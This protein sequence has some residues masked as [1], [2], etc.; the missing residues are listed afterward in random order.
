MHRCVLYIL[1]V[2]LIPAWAV[3]QEDTDRDRRE[4]LN[5]TFNGYK[6]YLQDRKIAAEA[7][8]RKAQSKAPDL[9]AP[10]YNLG[11]TQYRS[12]SYG[13]AFGYFKKAAEH[14]ETRSERH[15]AYH[16]MGNVLMQK[17]DYQGAVKAYKEALKNNPAD[18][19]TRYN[20]ALAKEMLKKNPPQNQNQNQNQNQDQENKDGEGNQDNKDKGDQGEG[21]DS[22][23]KGDS[24]K[25]GS[26]GEDGDKEKKSGDEGDE[27]DP[28]DGEDK[29]QDK[30]SEKPGDKKDDKQENNNKQKARPKMDQLSKQNLLNLLEALE[31]E[32]KRVQ[33]KVQAQKVKGKPIKTDK[34]W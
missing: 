28:K 20:Y 2:S 5:M 9:S 29:S 14:A 21:D 8:F 15:Q 19:E 25:G 11:T 3:A 17:K 31:N 34:D 23:Q 1:F 18:D 7:T 16:N 13:E 26:D 27:D 12:D 10:A 24:D 4:A 33:E 6:D 32:E 30:P 22:D